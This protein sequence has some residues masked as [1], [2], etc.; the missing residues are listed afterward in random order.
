MENDKNNVQPENDEKLSYVDLS[1]S[2]TDDR[3]PLNFDYYE[4]KEKSISKVP[5]IIVGCAVLALVSSAALRSFSNK[6]DSV[7]SFSE[8]SYNDSYSASPYA[9]DTLK[10]GS[11]VTE[12]GLEYTEYAEHIR[13]TG[14]SDIMYPFDMVIPYSVNQKP[15]AEIDYYV[16]SFSALKSLTVKNP[17]CIFF[18]DNSTPVVDT[19][20]TVRAAEDSVAHEMAIKYGNEFIAT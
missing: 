20:V 6:K 1:V 12:N 10:I 4:K 18:E 5:L 9:Y 14:C 3:I 17:E 16:F 11:G 2:D 13:I 7:S 19:N 15:V 8:T